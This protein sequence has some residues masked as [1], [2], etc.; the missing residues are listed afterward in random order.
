MRV[1]IYPTRYFATLKQ[2]KYRCRL[3]GT[4]ITLHDFHNQSPDTTHPIY[5]VLRLKHRAVFLLNSCLEL[6]SVATLSMASLL[7]KLREHFAE[8]LKKNYL[9]NL[10]ILNPSICVDLGTA[11]ILFKLLETFLESIGSNKYKFRLPK[12]ITFI[13]IRFRLIV[14]RI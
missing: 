4:Y 8:F 2:S 1:G 5:I 12:K 13:R 7:P 10:S 3:T 9:K 14:I 6:F 11:T